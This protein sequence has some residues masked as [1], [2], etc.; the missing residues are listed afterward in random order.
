MQGNL[1]NVFQ[2]GM[3]THHLS[4]KI[5]GPFPI[6][7]MGPDGLTYNPSADLFYLV[8]YHTHA[9]PNS[10]PQKT[11]IIVPEDDIDEV[12]QELIYQ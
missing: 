9:N 6:G 8:K 11:E 5:K 2:G 10:P 1:S 12:I 4:I 3:H 7:T